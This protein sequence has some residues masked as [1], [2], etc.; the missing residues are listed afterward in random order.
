MAELE[1]MTLQK[2]ISCQRI[3]SNRDVG[4]NWG[5]GYQDGDVGEVMRGGGLAEPKDSVDR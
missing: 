2:Q 3:V 5:E 1:R 4:G